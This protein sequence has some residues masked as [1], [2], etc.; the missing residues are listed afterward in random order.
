[1]DATT[2]F[3]IFMILFVVLGFIVSTKAS[4]DKAKM[5]D[6]LDSEPS[7]ATDL[8]FKATDTY[9][10][11]MGEKGIAVDKIHRRFAFLNPRGRDVVNYG[12][13]VRSEVCVDSEI[14]IKTDRLGQVGGAM[15][16]GMLTGGVGALIGALGA[17]KKQV[18][19]IKR[20]ELKI[21]V[22]GSTTPTYTIVFGS[23]RGF[24]ANQAIANASKWHDLLSI[25][26]KEHGDSVQLA[27]SKQ[28]SQPQ[29]VADELNKYADLLKKGF[30]SEDEFKKAK[31]ALL[32][33]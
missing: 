11:N 1:M 22:S 14:L 21:I 23:V 29:S 10:E 5:Q 31:A 2:I 4:E 3:L 33:K 9:F 20:V 19:N 17:K 16:G 27:S 25:A 15:L 7:F 8:P 6:L 26:I 32:S 30:L 13:I 24:D 18:K 12:Q 28:S